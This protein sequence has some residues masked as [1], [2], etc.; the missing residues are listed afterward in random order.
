[1]CVRRAF[2]NVPQNSSTSHKALNGGSAAV[3]EENGELLREYKN[4]EKSKYVRNYSSAFPSSPRDSPRMCTA[5][6]GTRIAS[7][8]HRPTQLKKPCATGKSRTV[9]T[10]TQEELGYSGKRVIFAASPRL[11]YSGVLSNHGAHTWI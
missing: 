11:V 2:Q 6:W 9:L 10:Y 8:K 3:L 5:F 7:F 4:S 1:M